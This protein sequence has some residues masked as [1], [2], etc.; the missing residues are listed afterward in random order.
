MNDKP[1]DLTLEELPGGEFTLEPDES[2]E[3]R[4]ARLKNEKNVCVEDELL[5]FK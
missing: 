1:K 2:P 4:E 3:E 5:E